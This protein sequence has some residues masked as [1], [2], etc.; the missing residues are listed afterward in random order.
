MCRVD[1]RWNTNL[2]VNCAGLRSGKRRRTA[3]FLF[4]GRRVCGNDPL[5]MAVTA[6]FCEIKF[7]HVSVH[8]RIRCNRSSMCA[9]VWMVCKWP[10]L[11][12]MPRSLC[13]LSRC[14]GALH[15]FGLRCLL[16]NAGS[17][18]VSIHAGGGWWDPLCSRLFTHTNT[19]RTQ[20]LDLVPWCDS[21]TD[22]FFFI[23]LR[24]R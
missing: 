9:C 10:C 4:R 8:V 17:A 11:F 20:K 22:F 19:R 2:G 18:A 15:Y 1:G 23:H 14:V 3:S 16:S 13:T 24:F 21:T 5:Y 12:V 6:C 7:L